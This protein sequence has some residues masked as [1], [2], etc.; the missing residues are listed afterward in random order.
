MGRIRQYIDFEIIK[1]KL[2]G[3]I[4]ESE[5]KIFNRWVNQKNEHLNFY[6]EAKRFYKNGSDFE[7]N[8]V[9][10]FEI[11]QKVSR[12][13]LV[14]KAKNNRKTL[15]YISSIAATIAIVLSLYFFLPNKNS[16][17]FVEETFQT[18]NPGTSKAM[19]I[20]DDGSTYDLSAGRSIALM[21][22]GTRINSRGTE[23]NYIEKNSKPK[24]V[25]YNTLKIPKGG[26]F[27]VTLSD[28]TKVWLN[29][30]TTF[31]YPVQ[32]CGNEREVELIGEAFFEVHKDVS[33]PFIVISNDQVV[34]VLGTSFNISSYAEDSITY[35]TLVEGSVSVSPKDSPGVLQT[36][37]PNHQSSYK[38]GEGQITRKIVDVEQ[39]TAWKEGL[40][41]FKDQPLSEIMKTLSRWYNVDIKFDNELA[42]EV[43]FT[44]R[45]KRYEDFEKILTLIEKTHEVKFHID[46]RSITII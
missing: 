30:E 8:P 14:Y 41:Y 37:L 9:N 12:Q 20:L 22:G 13:M 38:R 35:T 32:F 15:V 16:N 19:L 24:K 36:L 40:F 6:E 34:E 17:Q 21:E 31:R 33:K 43:K 39:F 27:F 2:Y 11:W 1:K 42:S 29:S 44:G 23:I 18:I 28:S 4:S 3:S 45:L 10:L 5:E 26:E 7:K 46:G 25:K